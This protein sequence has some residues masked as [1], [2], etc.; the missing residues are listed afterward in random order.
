ML[1]DT[2]LR[3]APASATLP[4][5]ACT[6]MPALAD[7]DRL[8]FEV[9]GEV[10]RGGMGRII[11]A[12]DRKLGRQVAIKVCL[13][14]HASCHERLVREAAVLSLLDHPAIPP[15][16]ELGRQLSGAPYFATRLIRGE[17]LEARLRATP[18]RWR[19]LLPL[20]AAVADV[21]TYVHG[22][23]VVHRDLKPSNILIDHDER[24]AIVDWG[25]ARTL[26][27]SGTAPSAPHDIDLTRPGSAVG[28]PG[29]WAPEQRRG[30]P[31]DE[32]ADVHALGAIAY[33]MAAGAPAVHGIPVGS[34]LAAAMAGAPR[35]LI[36]LVEHATAEDPRNRLPSAA[37]F[38]GELRRGLER[39]DRDGRLVRRLRR[40][41][42]IS[43]A[44]VAL[45]LVCRGIGTGPVHGAAERALGHVL[46]APGYWQ[47]DFD[48]M[49]F[50]VDGDR[51]RGVYAH[52][53]GHFEGR[54]VDRHVVGRWCEAPYQTA[55]D[56]GAVEFEIITAAGEAHID[57]HW[58]YADD[59]DW[60]GRWNL[61]R[62]P[63]TPAPELVARLRTEPWRCH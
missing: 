51:V 20:L 60:A 37:A 11:A 26:R 62:V 61:H 14:D 19:E 59:R 12:T 6:G 43:L 35:W 5:R 25:I 28:T 40:P 2:S 29:Y 56:T 21:V 32:T 38:A 44:L 50:A 1:G 48:Q 9:A 15:V 42:R 24:V 10:A 13:T 58:A 52:D 3:T 57:G 7:L 31:G 46:V 27:A 45:L 30:E 22:R 16:Y 23:G 36:R 53:A 17:T 49:I 8:R 55:R 63:G 34:E 41:G 33:R 47:G 4:I 54:I 18:D 39:G